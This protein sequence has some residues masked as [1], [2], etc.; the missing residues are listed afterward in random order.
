MGG[1][2]Q[3]RRIVVPEGR[4]LDLFV[5]MIEREGALAIRCPMVAIHDAQ[6]AAPVEAWLRRLVAGVHDDLVF[7][8]GEGISRL[9][10]FAGRAGIEPAVVEAMR[11]ARK[12]VRG[13]KPTRALRTIGLAP[14]I[15]ADPETT[16]G[17]V[18]ALSGFDLRGQRFGVQLYPG[19]P[20]TLSRFLAEAGASADPV[21]PYRYA[22][23]ADEALVIQTIRAIVADEVDLIA[24]TS[25]PQVRRLDE[26][27]RKSGLAEP[28]R[29]AFA[30]V[31]IAAV[32]PVT[33]EAVA[34]AGWR[35]SIMPPDNFHLKPFL[36]EIAAAFG[37]CADRATSAAR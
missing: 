10:G 5:G 36:G 28:L 34:A 33:A 7:L 19:A 27:A 8:T 20:D 26:V 14:D 25:S 30:R 4:A 35:A 6:D 32:G 22:S 11:G 12:I 18:A 37:S 3:G 31:P 17:I 23:A 9:L 24:F 1:T 16:E 2:L 29:D 15:S 13:P 21:L